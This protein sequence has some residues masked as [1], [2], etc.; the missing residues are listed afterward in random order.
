MVTSMNLKVLLDKCFVEE[1]GCT[2]CF[3]IFAMSEMCLFHDEWIIS[4]KV[5]VVIFVYTSLRIVFEVC[6][7]EWR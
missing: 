1:V 5:I 7:I 3:L 6:C 2:V 4:S